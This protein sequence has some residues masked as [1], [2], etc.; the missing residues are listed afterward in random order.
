M[1]RYEPDFIFKTTKFEARRFRN[2]PCLFRRL[3]LWL[4]QESGISLFFVLEKARRMAGK[5]EVI[6]AFIAVDLSRELRQALARLS[7]ALQSRLGHLPLRWVPPENIHLTL[8]FLGDISTRNLRIIQELLAREAALYPP[9]EFSAGTL[10]AFP[11]PRHPRVL[12]VGVQ[13]PRVLFQL[14]EGIEKTLARLGYPPD[15]K[16]F[17]PHL[18]L[19]RM[20]RTARG[21]DIR[22]LAHALRHEHVGYLG[23]TRVEEIHLY[24]SDLRPSG[25][26]YTRLF[27]APLRP[28]ESTAVV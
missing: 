7:E 28:S 5:D 17:S 13:A 23:S 22:N 8:K 16:P 3:M 25:A 15:S 14:Q 26:V 6:R 18:T 4:K 10:G 11:N 27:T 20:A 1:Y 2:K 9:F 12:W 19:A 24:R 21:E